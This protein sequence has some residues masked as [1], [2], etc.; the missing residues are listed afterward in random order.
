MIK[1][2]MVV[3]LIG[4]GL[5]SHLNAQTNTAGK[6]AVFASPSFHYYGY[7]FTRLKIVDDKR[8]GQS[9]NKFFTS[10][11]TLLLKKFNQKKLEIMFRRKKGAIP[12]NPFPTQEG[13]FKIDNDS[14]V[15]I[16]PPARLSSEILESLIAAYKLDE[17]NGIGCVTVFECFDSYAMTVTAD[18]L[19]FDI[20]TRKISYS[21]EIV[22]RDK[23]SYNSMGDWK[24]ASIK[25]MERLLK[26]TVKDFELYAKEHKK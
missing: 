15:A 8:K 13:M 9:F 24:A 26:L 10:L 18:L 22:S 1:R 23:N 19:F 7:D 14:V 11:N 2:N 5:I 6:E 17:T 21:K 3:L 20:S 25:A 4:I 16:K 12:F